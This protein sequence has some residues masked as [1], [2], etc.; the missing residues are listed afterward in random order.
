M[1][2]A[3]LGTDTDTGPRHERPQLLRP[4]ATAAPPNFWQGRAPSP[5]AHF[6][7]VKQ[8]V[9]IP[10]VATSGIGGRVGMKVFCKVTAHRLATRGCS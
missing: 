5:R 6:P 2:S 7:P 1:N 3:E 8:G 4:C 9:W 10:T